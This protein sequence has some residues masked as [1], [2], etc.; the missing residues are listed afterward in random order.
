[1]L[2]TPKLPMTPSL[3]IPPPTVRQRRYIRHWKRRPPLWLGVERA[4]HLPHCSPLRRQHAVLQT[5]QAAPVDGRHKLACQEAEQD[6]RG[7]VMLSYAVG[8]LEVLM[9]HGG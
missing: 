6:P 8:H 3:P 1:M 5:I 2:P 7:E 4:P 9:K